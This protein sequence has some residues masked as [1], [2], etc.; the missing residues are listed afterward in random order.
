[1]SDPPRAVQRRQQ[2]RAA[3]M[4]QEAAPQ[5]G[6]RVV[7]NVVPVLPP[8]AFPVIDFLTDLVGPCYVP[9][10]GVVYD[11]NRPGG[12]VGALRRINAERYTGSAHAPPSHHGT[13]GKL[14]EAQAVFQGI[15]MMRGLAKVLLDMAEADARVHP[16]APP[17]NGA[18][19]AEL[20]ALD[21]AMFSVAENPFPLTHPRYVLRKRGAADA[22]LECLRS[23]SNKNA[24]RD[25]TQSASESARSYLLYYVAFALDDACKAL[26]AAGNAADVGVMAQAALDRHESVFGAVL[27]DAAIARDVGSFLGIQLLKFLANRRVLRFASQRGHSATQA[28]EIVDGLVR[29]LSLPPQD[30]GELR[31]AVARGRTPESLRVAAEKVSEKCRFPIA[32]D[33]AVLILNYAIV[34]NEIASEEE[35]PGGQADPLAD[36]HGILERGAALGGAANQTMLLF[37]RVGEQ[38]I[39]FGNRGQLVRGFRLLGVA[40]EAME[41][42]FGGLEAGLAIWNGC[43]RVAKG[44]HEGDAVMGT[45]G[46]IEIG[47]GVLAGIGIL[48]GVP[49]AQPVA[50]TLLIA[51]AV[52][53][54]IHEASHEDVPPKKHMLEL[55][56]GVLAQR[57]TGEGERTIVEHIGVAGALSRIREIITS[58][59]YRHWDLHDPIG[60]N[61]LME[62]ARAGTDAA[63]RWRLE[64]LNVDDAKISEILAYHDPSRGYYGGRF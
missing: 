37:G 46:G 25:F 17:V 20:A 36:L 4:L 6:D 45:L 64:Q 7:S 30:A 3:Q 49:G 21:D 50:T 9:L 62:A 26:D 57:A 31:R 18:L 39:A 19:H 1:M 56:E 29:L 44:W 22:L 47:A 55:V 15:S 61:A 16:T 53:S 59:D 38:W 51:V 63:A 54:L 28:A 27:E 42:V 23:E 35:T 10:L 43:D 24:I 40:G 2:F 14:H 33:G 52:A 11:V 60:P 48:F 58:A 32:V 41:P 12:L 13:W 34:F 8:S 5:G